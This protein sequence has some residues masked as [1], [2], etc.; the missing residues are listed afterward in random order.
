MA[1]DQLPQHDSA[2][3]SADRSMFRSF[4]DELGSRCARY[5]FLRGHWD[6]PALAS[7]G[8]DVDLLVHPHDRDLC[9]AAFR[10]AAENCGLSVWQGWT[11]GTLTR[12]YAHKYC[13]IGG[14][15]FFDVDLHTAESAYGVPYAEAETL[16][17]RVHTRNGI[18]ELPA[19]LELLIAILGYATSSATIPDRYLDRARGMEPGRLGIDLVSRAMT[20]R[21]GRNFL[22]ALSSGESDWLHRNLRRVRRTVFAR[23]LCRRP[24]RGAIG[25]ISFGFTERVGTL[26]RP[27]GRVVAFLGTDG[28]GKTT[29]MRAVRASLGGRFRDGT[30]LELRVRPGFLPQLSRLAGRPAFQADAQEPVVPHQA[31]PSGWAGSLLRLVYYAT[32]YVVGYWVRCAPKRRR[33]SL[34]LF[35]RYHYDYAVDPLRFRVQPDHPWLA[36]AFQLAPAPEHTIICTAP[37]PVLRGRKTELPEPETVRQDREYQLLAQSLPNAVLIDTSAPLADCT[38][39]AIDF[40][41]SE[42]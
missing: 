13:P 31:P 38:R 5:C 17:E 6:Y 1:D 7:S 15:V 21:L 40:V 34:I 23:A 33:N 4:V 29:L 12:L 16:L 2:V 27:R 18:P 8:G 26:W 36:R 11:N 9:E 35:D 10:A 28:S 14:H 22:L 39:A 3:E 37:L 32:D 20:P 24:L 19:D 42:S 41:L 25:F 30:V